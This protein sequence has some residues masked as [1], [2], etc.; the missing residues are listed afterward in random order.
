MKTDALI[1]G[2]LSLTLRKPRLSDSGNYTCTITAFG[3]EQRLA[4]VQLQV[5]D[6]FPPWAKGL[7]AVSVVLVVPAV[8]V[9]L[10]IYCYYFRTVPQVEVESGV[11]SVQLPCRALVNLLRVSTVKWTDKDNRKVRVYQEGSDQPEE[12]D[13]FY[14]N[15]TEMKKD[16]LKIGDFSLTLTHPTVTDTFTC[17]VYREGRVLMEKQVE[18]KVKVPKVEVESGAES[19]QLPFI[20]T[21]DLPEDV[22]V[23]W[24]DWNYR[25]VHVYQDGSDRPEEQDEFYRNRTEMKKDLRRTGDL[26]LT[27]KHPTVRDTDIFTCRVYREGRVQME[28][29]VELKVK[30]QRPVKR[31]EDKEESVDIRNRSSSTDPTPLMADQSV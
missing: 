13:D 23:K 10:F 16:L 27:H 8:A 11:K 20:T 9:G 17:R 29:Q 14:R 19:V 2:D 15:R 26:S 12:Q 31:I 7:V 18:L 3:N 21:A 4:D 25:K 30:G 24:R 28:K 1:T 22:T 6:P 5:K